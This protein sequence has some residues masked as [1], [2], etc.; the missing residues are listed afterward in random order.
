MSWLLAV[1][2]TLSLRVIERLPGQVY[3][4]RRWRC[5]VLMWIGLFNGVECLLWRQ[6]A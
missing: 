3:I 5:L 2:L 6:A 4:A 1:I